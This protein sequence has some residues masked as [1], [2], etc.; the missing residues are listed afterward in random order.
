MALKQKAIICDLDGTLCSDSWRDHLYMED[1]RSWG[2]AIPFDEPTRHVP[3]IIKMASAG[4]GIKII[5]LTGRS[6]EFRMQTVSWLEKY[7]CPAGDL[8]MRDR[9]NQLNNSK[10]KFQVY[11]EKI[12]KLDLEILFAIDDNPSVLEMW[13]SISIPVLD[14]S[15][16]EMLI[17]RIFCYNVK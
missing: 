6:D 13:K 11:E 17:P 3:S 14:V 7:G 15:V 16:K 2:A 9:G 8:Y 10:Y 12:K 5:Y 1:R 4:F